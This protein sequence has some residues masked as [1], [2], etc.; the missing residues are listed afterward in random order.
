MK[1]W[2]CARL[3]PAISPGINIL[4]NG[5]KIDFGDAGGEIDFGDAGGERQRF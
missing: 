3:V 5:G 1:E 4:M 2:W